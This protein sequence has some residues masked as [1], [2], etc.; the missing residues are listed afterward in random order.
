MLSHAEL[1]VDQAPD[2]FT[3]HVIEAAG[4]SWPPVWQEAARLEGDTY[5]GQVLEVVFGRGGR[6]LPGVR[7]V[8]VA[9]EESPSW[10]AWSGLRLY[11]LP[12]VAESQVGVLA[13]CIWACILSAT[14]TGD[15]INQ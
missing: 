9:T 7:Y 12:G 10:V 5:G 13:A 1:E 6:G 11:E 14:C 4:D 15:P 2:G 3:A 8:R